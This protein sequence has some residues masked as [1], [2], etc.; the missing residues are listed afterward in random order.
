MGLRRGRPPMARLTNICSG[1]RLCSMADEFFIEKR[2]EK[3]DYAIRKPGA[4]RKRDCADTRRGD[5]S[6]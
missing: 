1:S 3:G 5:R 4:A 6:R 2:T